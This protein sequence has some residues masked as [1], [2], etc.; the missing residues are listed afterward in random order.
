[1]DEAMIGLREASEKYQV[2]YGTLIRRVNSD[3]RPFKTQIRQPSADSDS[4]VWRIADEELA[5]L[6]KLRENAEVVEAQKDLDDLA[7]EMER[8]KQQL[9][10]QA[11]QLQSARNDAHRAAA[12]RDKERSRAEE[13]WDR[14]DIERTRMT[15]IAAEAN[16][17][18]RSAEASRDQ[19]MNMVDRMLDAMPE[20]K[21]VRRRAR[22]G[23][24]ET[25]AGFRK[26]RDS[27]RAIGSGGE[28]TDPSDT[29]KVDD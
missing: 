5:D 9:A 21:D 13:A 17:K 23:W 24:V 14:L 16:A 3:D 19:A 2:S 29:E 10:D 15:D 20:T 28:A 12:D 4:S 7:A 11:E 8:L 22:A 18:Q 25:R 27:L 26:S 6:Y 1:M